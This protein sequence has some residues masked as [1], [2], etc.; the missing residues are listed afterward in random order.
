MWDYSALKHSHLYLVFHST[1]AAYPDIYITCM[2][3]SCY[4]FMMQIT[5]RGLDYLLEACKPGGNSTTL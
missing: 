3:L 5:L 1:D 2:V 4:I